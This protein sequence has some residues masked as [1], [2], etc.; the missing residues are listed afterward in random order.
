MPARRILHFV[1]VLSL[2]PFQQELEKQA[3]C[4]HLRKDY[5]KKNIYL[6]LSV[7]P[8]RGPYWGTEILPL[9]LQYRPSAANGLIAAR[10]VRPN[11]NILQYGSRKLG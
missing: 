7:N 5:D 9:R 4:L 6:P 3:C 11:A 2:S 8:V 10:S 1:I